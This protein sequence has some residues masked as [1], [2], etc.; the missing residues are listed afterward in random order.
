M[1]SEEDDEEDQNESKHHSQSFVEESESEKPYEHQD[2]V[3]RSTRPR[4]IKSGTYN[5]NDS[6]LLVPKTAK[7]SV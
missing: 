5:V 7:V 1:S 4:I 2:G 6:W 3:R